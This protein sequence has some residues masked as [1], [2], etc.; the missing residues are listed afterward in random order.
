MKIVAIGDDA[1]PTHVSKSGSVSPSL[2]QNQQKHARV[3]LLEQK[4]L[5]VWGFE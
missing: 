5:Q 2:V 3:L 4:D 1:T